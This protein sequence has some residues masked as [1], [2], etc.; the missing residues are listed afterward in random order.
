MLERAWLVVSAIDDNAEL[1]G[2]TKQLKP[3]AKIISSYVLS[4]GDDEVL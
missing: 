1:S 2:I 4:C 3:F